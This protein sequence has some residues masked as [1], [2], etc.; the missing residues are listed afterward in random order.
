MPLKLLNPKSR[1]H[2]PSTLNLSPP[3]DLCGLHWPQPQA[4]ARIQSNGTLQAQTLGIAV[5]KHTRGHR[6][7][8]SHMMK[9][10]MRPSELRMYEILQSAGLLRCRSHAHLRIK[11][12]GLLASILRI[13]EKSSHIR[14]CEPGRTI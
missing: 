5:V 14:N 6:R 13:A 8:V 3:P 7:R 12:L 9:V 10:A 1:E 4:H 2:I 11:D